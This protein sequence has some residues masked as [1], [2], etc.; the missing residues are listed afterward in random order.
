MLAAMIAVTGPANLMGDFRA[1]YCAGAGIAQG[2]NPYLEEPQH[3]CEQ[4]ARPPAPPATLSSVTLPAPLPP[5]TL[6]LFVPLSLL[7]FPVAAECT[8][9][10]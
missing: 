9:R 1:F 7:P 6:L 10:S 8:K 3:S 5:A 4:R 2:A